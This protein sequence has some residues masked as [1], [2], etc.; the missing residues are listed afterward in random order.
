MEGV[1]E[2][3]LII[4]GKG[5]VEVDG[6]LPT[7]VETGDLV[8]IPAGKNQRIENIGDTDLLFY[9]ICTPRFTLDCNHF[10]E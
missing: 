9:C 7:E 1:D 2:R 5:R 6:I 10:T 8:V 3:Y 4:S